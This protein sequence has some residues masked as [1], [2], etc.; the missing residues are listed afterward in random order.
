[1]PSPLDVLRTSIELVKSGELQSDILASLSRVLQGFVIAAVLGVSLGMAVGR[2][3]FLENLL[4]P[5]LELLRPIPPL[6]FLP[7]MVLWFG[8][9][10]ELPR[11]HSI[12]Y[13]AFFPDFHHHVGGDQ[14]TSIRCC[15]GLLPALVPTD[16][17]CS[18]MWCIAGGD[19]GDNYR[20]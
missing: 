4:D 10:E 6:A 15:C 17:T 13:A 7:M 16:G 19:A 8:I 18:A 14:N 9:G 3:R 1:M 5:M 2:S 12:A 11:S 20:A